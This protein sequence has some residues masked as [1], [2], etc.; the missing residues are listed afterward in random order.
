MYFFFYDEDLRSTLSNLQ[1]YNTVLT[2]VTMLCTTSL[3][4]LILELHVCSLHNAAFIKKTLSDFF[5]FL[6]CDS[7]GVGI[8]ALSLCFEDSTEMGVEV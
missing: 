5:A 6:S 2:T 3:E 1:I 8:H 4:L 7:D